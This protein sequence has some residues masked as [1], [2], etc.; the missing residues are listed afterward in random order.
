MAHSWLLW[1]LSVWVLR[2][3]CNLTMCLLA[4]RLTSLVSSSPAYPLSN[5]LVSLSPH[6]PRLDCRGLGK[7]LSLLHAFP[8]LL[9]GS[10]RGP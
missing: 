8:R 9:P 6:V 10:L 2:L 5:R 3:L 7:S 4:T 1:A